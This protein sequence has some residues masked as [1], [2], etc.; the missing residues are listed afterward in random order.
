MPW[1]AL[2]GCV[3]KLLDYD[4]N[5]PKR[6]SNG[7]VGPYRVPL[8]VDGPARLTRHPS[9]GFPPSSPGLTGP[10]ATSIKALRGLPLVPGPRFVLAP[11]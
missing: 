11:A 8:R 4:Q 1:A 6:I 5:L 3:V 7:K 10:R 9:Q 2:G